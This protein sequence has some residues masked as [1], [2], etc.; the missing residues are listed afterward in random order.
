MKLS[1]IVQTLTGFAAGAAVMVASRVVLAAPQPETTVGGMPR[2]ISA[3]GW[4][5]DHLI[6]TTNYFVIALLAF[7]LG[8]M[9]LAVFM[10]GKDKEAEYDS[11]KNKRAWVFPIGLAAF[12]FLVVDGNLF[13]NSTMDMHNIFDNHA[14]ADADPNVVKIEIN[15]HQWA[16]DAR[17]AGADGKFNTKDDIITLN[18]IRV[19]VGVPVSMQLSSVDVIHALYLPNLRVKK[20]VVPGMINRAWF[21]ATQTGEF[22]I[23]CAQHCG[24]SHYKMKGL[25]TVLTAEQFA[26]WAAESSADNSR[27]F[28]PTDPN[29][30]WGWEW[31]K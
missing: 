8:W 18:D 27:R 2:D 20:D 5:I 25:L 9:L 19:P 14:K 15:A 13:V 3:D 6:H 31:K 17:Y 16:W 22:E 30:T 12:V 21:R 28:D 23:G 26:T 29:L 4:R 11:G 10:C 24:V 7:M 1:R